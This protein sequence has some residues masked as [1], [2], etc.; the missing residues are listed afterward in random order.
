M[1]RANQEHSEAAICGVLRPSNPPPCAEI[2]GTMEDFRTA[3]SDRL[4]RPFASLSDSNIPAQGYF[5]FLGGHE[6]VH[7]PPEAFNETPLLPPR[8][9][10]LRGARTCS[11]HT[12][13]SGFEADPPLSRESSPQT[14]R[15]GV[16]RE[17]PR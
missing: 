7:D 10:V 14:A 5:C 3:P 13:V 15:M 4:N 17:G 1:G 12:S 6:G 8:G 2:A 16:I 9:L 11:L